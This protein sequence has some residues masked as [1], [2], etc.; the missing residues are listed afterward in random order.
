MSKNQNCNQNR[1]PKADI[2]KLRH[3]C[4]TGKTRFRDHQECVSVLHRSANSRV[5]ELAERGFTKRNE[6]RSYPCDKCAGWHIS[7]KSNWDSRKQ[8][9]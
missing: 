1:R 2:T 8:A 3:K 6:V 5:V 7:S 9:A 4:P